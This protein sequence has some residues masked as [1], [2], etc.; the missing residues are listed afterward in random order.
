MSDRIFGHIPGYPP[1]SSFASRRALHEAGV[2]RPLQAG[3][4]G[5]QAEGAE[6]IVLSGGYEDDADYGAVILYTGQGGRDPETGKQVAHQPLNRG[7]MALATSKL[8]GLPVRIV[9]GKGASPYAPAEGYRY[10]GLYMVDAYWK[11]RGAA[12]Y[13]VWQYRLVRAD[14]LLDG[15]AV[16]EAESPYGTGRAATSLLRLVRDTAMARELKAHYDYRCQ[17]CGMRLTT[18]AGP[19]AEAAHIRPLGRPHNG[20]DTFD[21]L[22]CLCPNHHVLFDHGAFSLTDDLSF[23]LSEELLL[24]EPF[25]LQRADHRP[26]AE[27][28][29]YHRMH[30]FHGNGS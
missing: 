15:A 3:I 28:L 9:R 16:G 23:I 17:V 25:L 11:Q 21:N 26:A 7:N 27:H 5:L 8:R 22:L 18:P 29:A 19:Y 13:F 4:A 12:G 30:L 14:R 1:G 6:S 10:D 24:P 20:P 2:H